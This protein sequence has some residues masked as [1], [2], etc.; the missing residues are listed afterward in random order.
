MYTPDPINTENIILSDELLAL[1]E[2]LAANVHENWAAARVSQSWSYGPVRDD[3]KKETPCLLPYD[4]LPEE[5]K[6]YDRR[7]AL[8]SLKTIIALGYRIEKD[9]SS[10]KGVIESN[11]DAD[12]IA[13]QK[14]AAEL[15]EK[16]TELF[17]EIEYEP[18]NSAD[19]EDF[20]VR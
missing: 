4:Q 14:L 12:T 11:D 2:K 19:D 18:D 1:T 9:D 16:S 13:E 8:E 20:F 7:S 3:A 17:G 6:E 15:D 5:E 10:V